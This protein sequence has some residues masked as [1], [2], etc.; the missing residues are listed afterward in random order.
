[1]DV[2]SNASCKV[3]QRETEGDRGDVSSTLVVLIL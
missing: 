1:M 2:V 3:R